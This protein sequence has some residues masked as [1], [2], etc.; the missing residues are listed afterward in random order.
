MYRMYS[1]IKETAEGSKALN[2][3]STSKTES[4]YTIKGHEHRLFIDM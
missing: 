2:F 1:Y 3:G 4:G